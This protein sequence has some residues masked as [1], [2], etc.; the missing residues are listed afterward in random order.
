MGTELEK[1]RQKPVIL[2]VSF[3]T[4][5]NETRVKTIDVI[6]T[7]I[8]EK[9]PEYEI[10]RA[11]TSPT[12]IKKLAERDGLIIDNVTDAM[13]R[14]V[15]DGIKDVIIQPTLVIPGL[16]YDGI[17]AALR[18]FVDQFDSIR[19]GLPLLTSDKDIEQ[20][21]TVLI[22]N[23]RAY[24]DNSA[25]V[26]VG[27]GTSHDANMMYTKLEK[28]FKDMGYPNCFVG[29]VESGP[30]LED[31]MSGIAKIDVDKA[32]LVPLMIVAGDHAL[33]DVSGDDEDSWLNAF[34]AKGY[35]VE[36]IL[37]G[38]GEYDGI[39]NMFA[40]HISSAIADA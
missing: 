35:A 22:D 10:R 14:L 17:I 38:L 7:A 26:F 20:I 19:Y 37:K 40:Q 5:Y 39:W 28:S 6:E 1:E 31:V 3:G 25:V 29:T 16:E 33:N 21:A 36:C 23:V 11:F 15:A 34:K 2:V 12:I 27:H 9:Y 8:G 4:S 32:V 24:T 18:P 30:T 13:E